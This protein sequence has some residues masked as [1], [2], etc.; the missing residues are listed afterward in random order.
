MK[1]ILLLLL[2]SSCANGR[3]MTFHWEEPM[4]GKLSSRYFGDNGWDEDAKK[5][6]T[7]E[8]LARSQQH[9]DDT[10]YVEVV[11]RP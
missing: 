11:N 2:C 10:V 7:P 3:L 6:V 1:Y 5:L 9:V 8:F 4:Q